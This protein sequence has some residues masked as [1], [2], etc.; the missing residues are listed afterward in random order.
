MA[1]RRPAPRAKQFLACLFLGFFSFEFLIP[2]ISA[3]SPARQSHKGFHRIAPYV[4][5]PLPVVE[6]MLKV[7]GVGPT[8]VVYDLG[9]GDGRIVIMA[10]Q[11][12]GARGVGIEINP[13][14]CRASSE[15]IAKL[16]LEGRARILNEDMFKIN[17]RPATVVTLYLKTAM[18]EE[19]R[20]ILERD[21]R[22]GTRVVTQEFQVPGW[23]P[24]K[25]VEMKSPEDGLTYT[26]YLYV[27]P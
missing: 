17:V 10:A 19:L 25:V 8:D 13:Q 14:L 2:L 11:E 15:R 6:R 21:L 26:L 23:T 16:G 1:I 9:S 27:R 18:N 12:F 7:A 20:P 5:T 22:P 3:A 4:P 24:Q